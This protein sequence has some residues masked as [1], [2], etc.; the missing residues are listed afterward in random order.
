MRSVYRSNFLFQ[1]RICRERIN[2]EPGLLQLWSFGCVALLYTMAPGG[3]LQQNNKIEQ[4]VNG[5]IVTKRDIVA[6]MCTCTIS[7]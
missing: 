4:T 6:G 3:I 2:Y 7:I 5:S 1:K